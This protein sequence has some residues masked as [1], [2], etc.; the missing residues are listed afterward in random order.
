MSVVIALS[1]SDRHLEVRIAVLLDI[2]KS[3]MNGNG[4]GKINKKKKLAPKKKAVYI[5]S[6]HLL[7]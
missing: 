5:V 7:L 3:L 2:L 6:I 4:T 1:L